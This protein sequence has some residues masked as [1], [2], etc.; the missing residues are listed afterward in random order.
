MKEDIIKELDRLYTVEQE[1]KLLLSELSDCRMIRKKAEKPY[2]EI[3]EEIIT[4][5]FNIK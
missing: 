5:Y 3:Y 1:H 2:K 4:K